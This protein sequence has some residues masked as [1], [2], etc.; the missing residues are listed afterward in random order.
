MM[1]AL[2]MWGVFFLLVILGLIIVKE[3]D[4]RDKK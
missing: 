1:S 3:K 4:R 2:I